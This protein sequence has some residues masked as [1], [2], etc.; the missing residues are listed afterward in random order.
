M[1][2]TKEQLKI[3]E[4]KKSDLLIIQNNSHKDATGGQ[5]SNVW[6]SEHFKKE[7]ENI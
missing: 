3:P 1:F 5:E 6:T 7:I 4:T 2:Q